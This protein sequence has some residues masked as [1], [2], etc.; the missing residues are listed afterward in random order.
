LIYLNDDVIYMPVVDAF[1]VAVS[2]VGEPED[3]FG[4]YLGA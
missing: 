3:V 4:F 2:V 1:V